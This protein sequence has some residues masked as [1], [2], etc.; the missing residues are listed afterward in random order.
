MSTLLFIL[1]DVTFFVV[2]IIEFELVYKGLEVF[3]F[4]NG[5]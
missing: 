4:Q 2:C 5:P 3:H 1:V